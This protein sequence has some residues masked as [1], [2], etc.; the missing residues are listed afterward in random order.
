MPSVEFQGGGPVL[1]R[2]LLSATRGL[3]GSS[4]LADRQTM[5]TRLLTI[6]VAM[7]IPLTGSA[8]AW[9]VPASY[10]G[11]SADGG[12]VFFAT[13][14]KLVPGDTDNRLDVYVRSFDESLGAY[15]TRE[16]S[17]GPTGGN[18]AF[19]ASYDDASADGQRAFFS[20]DESLVGGDTDRSE[21]VYVREL[22]GGTTKLVSQGAT[23]CAP[24]CGSGPANATF[25]GAS[26]TGSRAFFVSDE[27]LSPDD[28]DTAFD[29]YVRQ[30]GSGE[31]TLVSAASASCPGCGNG[32]GGVVFQ[33]AS[34][35]GSIVVLSTVEQLAGGDADAGDDI[36]ARDV[37]GEATSLVSPV[38]N[39]PAASCPPTFGGVSA[40]GTHIFF[41][42]ND[43]IAAADLDGASDIYDW[44]GGAP[45]LVST[46][47]LGPNG[48]PDAVF[49]GTS[50]NGSVVAFSTTEPLLSEDTDSTTDVYRR[51]GGATTLTSTGPA[52]TGQSLP[53][54]F[55]RISADGAQIL[56]NTAER[57]T[58]GDVDDSQDV[59]E[60]SGATT[61]LVSIGPSGGNGEFDAAFAGL[62]GDGQ[63]VLFD[64]AEALV[65][66]DT[67]G[68]SD[69]YERSGGATSWISTGPI[70]QKGSFDPSLTGISV[71]GTHAFFIT[72]ERLAVDDLDTEGDVYDRFGA[73]T[74]LVSV[75]NSVALGP[76][77][78]ALTGTNPPSPNPSLTPALLGQA[79]A[80]TSIKVYSTPD[81]SGAPVATGTAAQLGGAGIPT[82]VEAGSTT[83]FR[84]TATDESGDTSACSSDAV[85]YQASAGGA[86]GGGGEG[87]GAPGGGGGGS[88]GGGGN[89]GTAPPGGGGPSEG[90]RH[91][92]PQ[93]RITFAPA[94][95]TRARRPVFR[96]ADAT[97]QLGTT[98][99]C[100]VDRQG[101]H[102]CSSP[103]RLKPL[104]RGRHVFKVI[105]AN[106]GLAE[107]APVSRK[108]KVVSG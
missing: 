38:G 102:G 9:A 47:P 20:T 84:A 77:T 28:G 31:T 65:S 81:C 44:S 45:A 23:A 60:R 22:S 106:S 95:R 80:G 37:D 61:S 96:F 16:V 87:G 98:F 14:E 89:G 10:A 66:Q 101:W 13:S 56:F 48:T 88:T 36:Y 54:A 5:R 90:E 105:G 67:D 52:A 86:P 58:G 75:G 79:E 70:G 46:G 85:V 68:A 3:S 103:Q 30:L 32:S 69:V 64:T 94:F 82:A 74:L 108:F 97:G 17:T 1:A 107:V 62:S 50:A 2:P 57:L 26:A 12:A 43:R 55:H 29:V 25:V 63:H 100:K 41:E 6:V 15:V 72:D 71:D 104:K 11:S 18:D 19:N 8:N 7:A 53:A 93:T 59:Y 4:D 51:A 21:D 33:G 40:D 73:N 24:G 99:L 92:V 76:P 34:S 83:T 91:L 27:P 49:D 39:C 35:D 78:P 42:T